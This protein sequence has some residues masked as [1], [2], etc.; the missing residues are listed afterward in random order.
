MIFMNKFIPVWND[1]DAMVLS[2]GLH[3]EINIMYVNLHFT[4]QYLQE[5][6]A[7]STNKTSEIK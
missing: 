4:Q 6:N 5:T 7:S 1:K 2:A 3:T